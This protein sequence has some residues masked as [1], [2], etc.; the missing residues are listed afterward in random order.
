MIVRARLTD[1]RIIKLASLLPP[2]TLGVVSKPH[3]ILNITEVPFLNTTD[4]TWTMENTYSQDDNSSLLSDLPVLVQ[5]APF[6]LSIA[7][8]SAE[9]NTVIPLQPPATNSSY[10]LQFYGPSFECIDAA[11]YQMEMFNYYIGRFAVE[12]ASQPSLVVYDSVSSYKTF[13]DA[14]L[15]SAFSLSLLNYTSSEAGSKVDS[16]NNWVAEIPLEN[17]NRTSYQQIWIQTYRESI[18]CTQMNAY[19]DIQL[20]YVAGVQTIHQVDVKLLEPVLSSSFNGST[21]NADFE[22]AS[23]SSFVALGNMLFGNVSLVS[24]A[25]DPDQ[26]SDELKYKDVNTRLLQTGLVACD[27]LMNTQWDS[28]SG[29]FSASTPISELDNP[30]WM[31][32]NGTLKLAIQDLANNITISMLTSPELTYPNYTLVNFTV[33]HNVYEYNSRNLLISYSIAVSF[34]VIAVIVGFLSLTENGVAHSGSFSAIMAATQNSAL[35][36]LTEGSSIGRMK[37]EV[38]DT[39]LRFG[40]IDESQSDESDLRTVELDVPPQHVAFGFSQTV[41]TLTKGQ[42]V[43]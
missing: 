25:S 23:F 24:T 1:C 2:A 20:E 14:L 30:P 35:A 31:C 10:S 21:E 13:P 15:Y 22:R 3:N 17:F 37:K 7:S 12:T 26:L 43:Y 40:V 9:T 42:N 18:V 19:F 6:V 41:S 36:V 34:A 39:R 27:E 11:E 8:E 32:R 28:L 4:A 29:S 38:Q 33:P 5:P 16:Y